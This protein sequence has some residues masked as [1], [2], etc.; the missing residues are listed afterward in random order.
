ML[1]VHANMLGICD[2][3]REETWS[4]Q[5]VLVGY[6]KNIEVQPMGRQRL[7]PRTLGKNGYIRY[8]DTRFCIFLT[9]QPIFMHRKTCHSHYLHNFAAQTDN[10]SNNYSM[11]VETKAI[12][13]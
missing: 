10:Y 8:K 7:R 12:R 11:Q 9:N 13:Q 4:L 3:S 6:K 1:P 5:R 2:P